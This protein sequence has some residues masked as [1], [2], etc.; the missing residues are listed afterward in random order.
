MVLK[1]A[2]WGSNPTFDWD[3]SNENEIWA[4]RIRDF[5]IEQCFEND[6]TVIPHK[7]AAT[8]PEKYGDRYLVRGRTDGGRKLIVIVQYLGAN[9]VRPVTAWNE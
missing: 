2:P 8:E 3:E 7:K 6:Y 1:F 4:H 5:E 9:F